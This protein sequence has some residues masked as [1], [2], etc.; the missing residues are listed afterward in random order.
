MGRRLPSTKNLSSGPRLRRGRI[1]LVE[2]EPAICELILRI[3]SRSEAQV[4][5]ART[6][7]EALRL[8]GGQDPYCLVILDLSLPDSTGLK[9]LGSIREECPHLPVVISSGCDAVLLEEI[10][11]RDLH[12]HFLP[13]PFKIE[14][15]WDVLK[16]AMKS[17]NPDF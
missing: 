10:L 4:D 12:L 9:I 17:V 11:G 16:D 14:A 1:L 15:F 2:D 8:F 3:L 7:G 13:K 6:G 5:V